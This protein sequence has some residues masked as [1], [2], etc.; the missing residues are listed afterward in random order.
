LIFNMVEN[1]EI[2]V[3]DVTLNENEIEEVI[4]HLKN[5]KEHKTNVQFPLA[6][7]LDLSVTYAIE[8]QEIE[9]KELKDV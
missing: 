7:D 8:N 1:E 4:S 6:C 9:T 2:E 3:I 5:L